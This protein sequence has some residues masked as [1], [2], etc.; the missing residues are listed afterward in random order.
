MP[1]LRRFLQD[2]NPDNEF[3]D[4]AVF[5]DQEKNPDD[6]YWVPH[7]GTPIPVWAL[8]LI[9]IACGV[10]LVA[11]GIYAS[12]RLGLCSKGRRKR[13][14]DQSA[15]QLEKGKKLATKTFRDASQR[16]GLPLHELEEHMEHSVRENNASSRPSNVSVRPSNASTVSTNSGLHSMLTVPRCVLCSKQFTA[17]DP[18]T[19]SHAC[20]HE[21]HEPCLLK[22]W[23]KQ[24]GEHKCPVCKVD[25]VVEEVSPS[26]HFSMSFR[27]D[28]SQKR[29]TTN[30]TPGPFAES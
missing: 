1:G 22:Y 6:D 15:A 27:R 11:L 29:T 4:M 19:H 23:K 3:E 30:A 7:G 13:E 18:V 21:Y 2:A 14:M 9:A 5:T 28:C 24:K 10:V 20:H 8:M 17:G 26:E 12:H 25:Y 16:D